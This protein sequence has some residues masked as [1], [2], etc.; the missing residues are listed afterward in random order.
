MRIDVKVKTGKN[1]KKVVKNDFADYEVWVKSHP[2]K[3]A[4]NKELL[5]TL[6]NYFGIKTNNLRIV[7]GITS[8]IKIIDLKE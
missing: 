6:A 7:K 8:P 4:A 2:I 5:E 1:E 3:G